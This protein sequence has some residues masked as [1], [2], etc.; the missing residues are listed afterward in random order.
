[1]IWGEPMIVVGRC[2]VFVC[3]VLFCTSTETFFGCL[4]FCKGISFLQVE[5]VT[6]LQIE[7]VLHVAL[8]NTQQFGFMK[9]LQ[10]R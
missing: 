7:R 1:M 3:V 9:L 2:L 8:G 10:C 4:V 5:F 6:L